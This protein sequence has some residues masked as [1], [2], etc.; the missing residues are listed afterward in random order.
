MKCISKNI[1]I[2]VVN[3]IDQKEGSKSFVKFVLTNLNG[4]TRGR[5]NE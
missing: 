2:D 1:V 3:F 5:Q 4:K